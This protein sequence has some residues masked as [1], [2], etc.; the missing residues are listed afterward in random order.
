ML[1]LALTLFEYAGQ[2]PTYTGGFNR[3]Y[4]NMD[5]FVRLQPLVL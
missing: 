2:T 3:L 5:D 1:T 4:E